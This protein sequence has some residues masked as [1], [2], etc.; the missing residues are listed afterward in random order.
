MNNMRYGQGLRVVPLLNSAATDSTVSAFVNV[1]KANWVTFLMAMGAND[2]TTTIT[3][4]CCTANST[5]GASLVAVPF[6]YR[7]SG[8]MGI[9]SWGAVTTADSAG[10]ALT[11]DYANVSLL[12]DIDPQDL[13]GDSGLTADFKYLRLNIACTSYG[14]ANPTSVLAFLEPR[15]R[16]ADPLSAS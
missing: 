7:V 11:S 8:E 16:R 14:A 10:Y 15:Y 1:D 6:R 5:T 2:T 3:V 13:A 12:I 9:D 4:Q